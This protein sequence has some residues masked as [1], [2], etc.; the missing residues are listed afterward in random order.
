VRQF[1]IGLLIAV[2]I[3]LVCVLFA[4]LYWKLA[5]MGATLLVVAL[6]ALVVVVIAAMPLGYLAA[7]VYYYLRPTEQSGTS[8][9]YSIKQGQEVGLRDE[10]ASASQR[11]HSDSR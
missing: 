8:V 7:A 11:D 4:V 10:G 5:L 1:L 3:V 6:A 9:S 2:P